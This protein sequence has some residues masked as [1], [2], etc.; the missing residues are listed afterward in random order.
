MTCWNCFFVKLNI[1]FLQ[2]YENSSY[3][4]QI[5]LILLIIVIID[6]RIQNLTHYPQNWSY[7]TRFR[8]MF[9]GYQTHTQ[10]LSQVY[11][12]HSRL[13]LK[14]YT[15]LSWAVC[16]KSFCLGVFKLFNKEFLKFYITTSVLIQNIFTLCNPSNNNDANELIQ[17]FKNVFCMAVNNLV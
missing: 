12:G 13:F 14:L 8:Y 16:V 15:Y 9:H 4:S 17:Q 6:Y 7:K 3:V 10:Q 11:Y 1:K 2:V 5:T